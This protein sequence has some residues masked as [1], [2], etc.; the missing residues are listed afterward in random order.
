MDNRTPPPAPD[1]YFILGRLLVGATG[2]RTTWAWSSCQNE[3]P[4]SPRR[5]RRP[6][7]LG[8]S[9]QSLRSQ[10]PPFPQFVPPAVV[11]QLLSWEAQFLT[12]KRFY[13]NHLFSFPSL[14]LIVLPLSHPPPTLPP[15]T[16]CLLSNFSGVT[17]AAFRKA[18]F[19][20]SRLGCFHGGCVPG[21]IH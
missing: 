6:Q 9:A 1:P 21:T 14:F 12:V 11:F 16:P 18:C 15:Y 19:S 10:G 17:R 3:V 5:A 13:S 4:R 20:A 8:P 7:N 2:G